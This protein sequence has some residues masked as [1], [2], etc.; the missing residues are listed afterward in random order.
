MGAGFFLVSCSST[1]IAQTQTGGAIVSD[2]TWQA[3]NSP[4]LVNADIIVDQGATLTIEPGTVVQMG[5]G[6]SFAVKNGAL[7]AKGTAA[8]PIVWTSAS[9]TPAP[10]NW[11]QLIFG[12]GTNSAATIVEQAQIRYGSGVRIDSASPTL[13]YLALQNHAGPAISMDLVSSPSGVGLSATGNTINGIS[14]PAGAITGSVKWALR[15]IPYVVTQGE[16]SVGARPSITAMSPATAERGQTVNAVISG[17]RLAGVESISFDDAGLSATLSGSATDSSVPVQ[18]AVPEGQPLGTVGFSLQTAAGAVRYDSGITVVSPVPTV[19]VTSIT[20]ASV[21]RAQSQSF[22]LTG[23]YLD[24]AQV[25]VP[26]GSGLTLS[27]LQTSANQ[28]SFDLAATSTATLGAKSL[29]VTNAA[30]PD[31]IGSAI[32]TVHSALPSLYSSPSPYAVAV[33]GAQHTLAIR[34]TDSDSVADTIIL[35]VADP[36]IASVATSSVTI[37]AGSMQAS[38]KITGLKPGM[39]V[40]NL[41]SATLGPASIQI[42]VFNPVM[43]SVVGPVLS[44]TVGVTVGQSGPV[45]SPAVKVT[46]SDGVPLT[47]AAVKVTVLDGGIVSKPVSVSVTDAARNV[48]SQPVGVSVSGV[49]R[50]AYSRPVGVSVTN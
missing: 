31:S 21:R 9:G 8:L 46:V 29:T 45:V 23:T 27:N 22:Q 39:T 28:A 47:S 26:S 12:P 41:T 15:G 19:S 11:G 34:L 16:I 3:S 32:V 49:A 50:A 43:G 24:G 13:N 40:L 42:F 6:L 5:A 38:V 36:T 30:L 25:A 33:D 18:I 20:P 7:N 1:V 44:P 35:S 17:T 2:T 4:Y 48:H 37:P 14:V 10:G